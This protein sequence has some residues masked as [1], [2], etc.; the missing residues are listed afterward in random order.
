MNSMNPTN[1]MN[2]VNAINLNWYVIQCKPR[3][4]LRAHHFLGLRGLCTY[5]PR[6]S[7]RDPMKEIVGIFEH[8]TSDQG[9]VR[10]LLN[11]INYQAS[12]Q[13]HHI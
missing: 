2:T 13:L 10:V 7:S 1:A 8:W 11:F 3:E 6:P 9:R 5:L 4:E 12:V